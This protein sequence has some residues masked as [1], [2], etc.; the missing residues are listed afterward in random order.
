MTESSLLPDKAASERKDER[1]AIGLSALPA[2]FS[3]RYRS[4]ADSLSSAD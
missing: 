4:L 3:A 1:A 2:S